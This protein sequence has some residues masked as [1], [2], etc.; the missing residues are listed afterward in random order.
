MLPLPGGLAHALQQKIG[1]DSTRSILSVSRPIRAAF[2]SMPE[3]AISMSAT[4][5]LPLPAPSRK[6]RL[7][8][9][10]EVDFQDFAVPSRYFRDEEI[11]R[12][13]ASSVWA[14]FLACAVD[15]WMSTKSATAL[16]SWVESHITDTPAP[17]PLLPMVKPVTS[18]DKGYGDVYSVAAVYEGT[19]CS[20]SEG[21][22]AHVL[23]TAIDVIQKISR[24]TGRHFAEL[25]PG[26][27]LIDEEWVQTVVSQEASTHGA[28][29]IGGSTQFTKRVEDFCCGT[30]CNQSEYK[31]RSITK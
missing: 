3:I 16:A 25:A 5:K 14:Q 23:T 19:K 31:P 24:E 28:V 27:R 2:D 11:K 6:P 29:S 21:Q 8:S 4:R 30:A 15:E 10:G 7:G 1:V 17:P 22:V 18:K 9:P 12:E 26:R 13:I 20:F